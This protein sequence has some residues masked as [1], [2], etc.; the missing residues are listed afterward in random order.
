ML[1]MRKLNAKNSLD[2]TWTL[3]KELKSHI[4][5]AAYAAKSPVSNQDSTYVDG[6]ARLPHH[7]SW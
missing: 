7:D 3:K 2:T 1:T 5:F 4:Y 6:R